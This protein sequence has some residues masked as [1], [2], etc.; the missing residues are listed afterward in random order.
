[1]F[2]QKIQQAC[3]DNKPNIRQNKIITKL[4]FLWIFL[5]N[6]IKPINLDYR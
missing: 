3:D 5:C 4:T 6:G 1:M 2:S